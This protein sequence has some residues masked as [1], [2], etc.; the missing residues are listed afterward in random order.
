MV[1]RILIFILAFFLSFS[2]ISAQDAG[3]H[4]PS[5]IIKDHESGRYYV[6]ATGDGVYTISA[7]TPDFTDWRVEDPIFPVGTWPSWIDNYV[8]GFNG[9]FWAPE[10]IYM[11]NRYYVYYSCSAGDPESAIGVVSS[12]SLSNPV[13]TDHGMVVFS[14]RSTPYGSIDPDVFF[15]ENGKFW[16]VWGSHLM[17]IVSTELDPAT[18]KPININNYYNLA[19]FDCEGAA[20]KYFNGYYYLFFNRHDCCSGLNSTYAI[21][22]GRSTSVTGPFLDRNG[23]DCKMYG[24][25]IF[26]EKFDKYTGPGHFGYGEG[27]LTYHYYDGTDRGTPKLRSTTLSFDS[28]GWPVTEGT[29]YNKYQLAT[30]ST[31]RITPRNA[32]TKAV[33]VY[34]GESSNGAN[35]DIWNYTGASYQN[36]IAAYTGDGFWAFVPT[37]SPGR[38]MDVFNLSTSP[39][40]NVLLWDIFPGKNQQWLLEPED[41]GWYRLKSQNSSNYLTVGGASDGANVLQDRKLRRDANRQMFRFDLVSNSSSTTASAPERKPVLEVSKFGFNIFPNPMAENLTIILPEGF[42]ETSLVHLMDSFGKTVKKSSFKGDSCKLN[43]ADLSS[44]FYFI[45]IM[46]GDRIFTGKVLKE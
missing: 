46:D 15:D 43:V 35:I 2:T 10:A 16:M 44:G 39:G 24:G 7:S 45:K 41:A 23:N 31:Y 9:H 8:P 30:G 5:R 4:D 14:D 11:N 34:N 18:A 26:L 13:W 25:S 28:E 21:H 38:T 33:E 3:S 32:Q 19:N 37:N 6:F 17:G 12:P 22:V 42:A 36:W 1:F 40:A 27:R 29:N 20:I